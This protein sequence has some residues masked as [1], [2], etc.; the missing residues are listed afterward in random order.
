MLGDATVTYVWDYVSESGITPDMYAKHSAYMLS[1]GKP[2][3]WSDYS[4]AVSLTG[5]PPLG[6]D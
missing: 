4:E 3:V 2:F 5:I 1:Q 6:W